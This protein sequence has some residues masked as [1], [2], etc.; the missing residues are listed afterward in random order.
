MPLAPICN[1]RVLARADLQSAC[2]FYLPIL[3][4]R[5][6]ISASGE[7]ADYKSARAKRMEKNFRPYL[8]KITKKLYNRKKYS[9]FAENIM[10]YYMITGNKFYN[11]NSL[12]VNGLI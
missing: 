6:Q 3:P 7:H 11:I 4:R 12:I 9:N 2:V 1:R 8:E 10:T 5:L